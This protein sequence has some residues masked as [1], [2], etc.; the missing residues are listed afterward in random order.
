[1]PGTGEFRVVDWHDGRL[2][3]DTLH[4]QTFTVSLGLV[5]IRSINQLTE[6]SCFPV[7]TPRGT[8]SLLGVIC[9]AFIASVAEAIPL[10]HNKK[11]IVTN[12]MII[13]PFYGLLVR[14]PAT[15]SPRLFKKDV[16][17]NAV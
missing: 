14:G 11:Q 8:Y 7:D 1:M 17:D 2:F 16:L 9:I 13:S 4:I 3:G 5:S 12:F 6:W 15:S 10:I